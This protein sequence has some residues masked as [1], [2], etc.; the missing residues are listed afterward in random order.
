MPR[1]MISQSGLHSNGC[2]VAGVG[3]TNFHRTLTGSV[4]LLLA[5]LFLLSSPTWAQEVTASIVGTVVDP[6][7]AAVSGATITAKDLDRG[8]VLTTTTNDAGAFNISGVPVGKYQIKA[9]AKGFQSAVNPAL[10]ITLNQTARL[11]F[12]LRIG[13]TTE[14]VEVSA[15]APLLQTDTSLLGN[16]VDAATVSSLPL[17]THNTNQLTLIS[18][19]GVITPNLFGFQAAQNSFGTGRP[20]VNG[21]REQENNFL[22]DGMDNNQPDNN[23]VGYVPAPDAVQEFNLITGSAPA[24]FGNYL[25]GVVNVTIKSGTNDFHGSLYEYLRRGGLNANSWQNNH[26]CAQN[27][28]GVTF[29]CGRNQA[30]QQ[31]APRAAL[32]Y[33]DF[34]FTFG[35]PIIQNK[36]FFFSDFAESLFSQPATVAQTNLIPDQQRVG[37]FSALCPEG[38]SGGICNNPA[39][40]LFDPA[41]SAN[42]A[43][44][45]AFANNQIPIGRFNSAAHAIVTSP[46]YPGGA[47]AN[48]INQ[49]KTNSYQGDLKIDFVPSE[50]DHV[51]GRYSQQFVTAPQSNSLQLLGD[52]DRTFPLKNFVLDETHTFSASLLNDARL[53]FQYFPVTEGFS[54]PTGQ[55][56]G[57]TFGIAGVAVSFLPQ[58]TFVGTNVGPIGNADLVQSFH[59]TTWQFEDTA[60]WTHGRHVIHG[61]FQAYHYIMND[62]FPGNAGLAGQ[63]IFNGQFTGNNGTSAGNAVADFLLGLPQDVQQG[64]GGGGNKYLRNSLFGIFAQDNWRVKNNLTLN[65][66][67]RYELTTARQ[68]NNGQDVNFNLITGAPSIGSG[69]NTYT[70]IGNFQ[71][72][73][74]FA[75]QPNWNSVLTRNTVVRAAYGISS[76]MEANGVNNLP[77]QNPPFVEAHELINPAT[78]ALPTSTLSQGFSGFPASACTVAA[79]QALSPACLSG[80]TLHLTNPNLQPAIDQQWNLTIQRQLGTKTSVSVGYVGNKI[81]HMSDI[82]IFNQDVLNPDGTV[83]PG[84]FAQPL[85][86]CCGAGNSPTIR[87]ND[88]S[89]IQR[90]NALQISL[91]QRAWE[92]LTFQTN[93][94][95]SKCMTNSLG[96]FGPFGDEEQLPGATSQTGF[97]F[98]F[99]N[100][101]NAKG[102]YGRCISDAASL[103]NGYMTYDLPFGK[104]RMFGGGVDPVVNAVIG[105]WSIASDFTLHSGFA[106]YPHG[107]DKSLT[108]SASPRPN[109]V[110]GVS[111]TGSGQF[112]NPNDPATPGV[113][114]PHFLN[115]ASVTDA[116]PGTFG[117]CAAGAFRGPGLA[118][119]DLSIVKAFQI[120]ERTNFQFLTQFINLTNTPILG[121]PSTS[122]GPTFGVITSSNPGRQVQFGMKLIF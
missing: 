82:F 78:Q 18:A 40:Q 60:T 98:F 37:D 92:G 116:A 117:T 65:L 17:S 46:F 119:S 48:N 94:T 51:M 29:S 79:L 6:S 34:G 14:T 21:A 16:L 26:A 120:S 121:A 105:G 30:G 32:H 8:T 9:E 102:D 3:R 101:Y 89:G 115:P 81:D 31:I 100:A 86:N 22:L 45:T 76:F 63:F 87:F 75:W 62:L 103:F 24:D 25:G 13:Q 90:Y 91:Q 57:A 118:T 69:Y 77:Y 49:F 80:A 59:D 11:N 85:I 39:H 54:N 95:W 64:N 5:A 23:D 28:D 47:V 33:D 2:R 109:C 56:L 122:T 108:G 36:L 68:T 15:I 110:P 111:Q 96:Y 53:G 20:Y 70:G 52:A 19:P 41:S 84:P 71:P 104:G 83:S 55:N 107:A 50:K 44:R 35:G 93:Y 74:G 106:L 58:M 72:R 27:A 7:G 61:G 114:G 112:T 113:F 12:Q 42:P 88:S 4:L 99:Q 1:L 73:I 66:G 10:T 67:L 97:G 38:F 43:T